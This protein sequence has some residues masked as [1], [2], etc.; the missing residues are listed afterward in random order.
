MVRRARRRAGCRR[1]RSLFQLGSAESSTA[2]SN[3]SMTP[4]SE[5][6]TFA[7][8][9]PAGLEP[10]GVDLRRAAAMEQQLRVALRADDD[11][12]GPDRNRAFVRF[13]AQFR[14]NA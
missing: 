7:A 5:V 2:S 4:A 11:A 9:E 10:A 13:N 14:F 3:G 8:Y 6:C 12:S 1:S